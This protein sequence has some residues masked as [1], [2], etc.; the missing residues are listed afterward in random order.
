MVIIIVIMTIIMI[1]IMI[2]IIIMIITAMTKHTT[3][4]SGP[5]HPE[6]AGLLPPDA[7]PRPPPLRPS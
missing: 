6:R 1:M 3:T 4:I 2:M 5:L 7:P